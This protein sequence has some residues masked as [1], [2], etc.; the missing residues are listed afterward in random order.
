MEIIYHYGVKTST[1][2]PDCYQPIKFRI[3]SDKFNISLICRNGHLYN[4]MSFEDFK[5]NCL[6]QTNYSYIKCNRCYSFINEGIN[7]YICEK[8]N[9]LFCSKCIKIHSIEKNH[10]LKSNYLNENRKCKIHQ[11]ILNSFCE[12]CLLNL[13]EQCMNFHNMHNIKSFFNII[14]SPHKIESIKEFN[15]KNKEKI[16]GIIDK[17]NKYKSDFLERYDNLN[18]LL[19]FLLHSINGKLIKNFNFSF[20]D[21]YNYENLEYCLDFLKNQEIIQ[22]ENYLEYLISGSFKKNSN[23]CSNYEKI[24]KSLENTNH[25]ENEAYNISNYGGLQYY[26]SNLFFKTK[27]NFDKKIQFYEFKNF[28]F[29]HI[30][31]FSLENLGR[32]QSIK[33]AKYN[34]VIFVNFYSKKNLKILQYDF[35]EKKLSMLKNEIKAKKS[36]IFD[37][38]QD[39]I[40]DKIGNIITLDAEEI[41]FWKAHKKNIYIKF[42]FI[43]G[44]YQS[45]DNISSKIFCAINN[46][47]IFFFSNEN[48]QLL[49]SFKLENEIEFLGTIKNE[50]ELACFHTINN[51]KLLFINLKY[52]EIVK[53]KEIDM[54]FRIIKISNNYLILIYLEEYLF[55]LKKEYYDFKEGNFKEEVLITRNLDDSFSYEA[56]III[57]SNDYIIISGN[58]NLSI[59]K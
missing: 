8:C 3:N 57:T 14:P 41:S 21:Y 12:D 46:K 38:F 9:Q 25:F 31:T 43:K 44:F 16:E 49:K 52:L 26:K 36:N 32:I 50:L 35:K 17:I 51:N 5:N 56:K 6:K 34:D 54:D 1:K 28:S 27:I 24:E 30:L 47:T 10:N 15:K 20:Y 2:C 58:N 39:Y 19:L 11:K 4:N 37:Y 59:L 22:N 7:N 40:N 48:L 45:L 55:K 18:N 23:C 29:Q 42:K 13:C 33:P 53:I